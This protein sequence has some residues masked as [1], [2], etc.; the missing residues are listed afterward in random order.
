MTLSAFLARYLPFAIGHLFSP[1]ARATWKFIGRKYYLFLLMILGI[2]TDELFECFSFDTASNFNPDDTFEKIVMNKNK[3]SV[4]M[5][6]IV[7]PRAITLMLIPQL[8][9][10]SL[11]TISTAGDPL[12]VFS[13]KC[14]GMLHQLYMSR[15]GSIEISRQREMRQGGFT[16]DAR[17]RGTYWIVYLRSFQ[18][19]TESSRVIRHLIMA[20]YVFESIGFMYGDINILVFFTLAIMFPYIAFTSLEVVVQVGKLFS[21]EDSDF[22]NMGIPIKL[23]AYRSNRGERKDGDTM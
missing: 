9:V 12:F 16:T 1:K 3:F 4:D 17:E 14:R 23:A 21:I 2:W 5:R 19:Y 18:V 6:A 22:R 13:D 8:T 20:F 7:A 11:Y 15:S 10:L